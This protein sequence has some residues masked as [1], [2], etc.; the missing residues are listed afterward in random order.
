MKKFFFKQNLFKDI[1]KEL[2]VIPGF[3]TGYCI[4]DSY[5]V[6]PDFTPLGHGVIIFL[7]VFWFCWS[8][9]YIIYKE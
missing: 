2:I 1:L 4:S 5:D 3:S 9:A 8:I 6:V 7:S